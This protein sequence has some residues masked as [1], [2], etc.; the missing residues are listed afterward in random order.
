[1][2]NWFFSGGMIPLLLTVCAVCLTVYLRGQPF[3]SP[4]RMLAALLPKAEQQK[5][6]SPFR[7]LMLALAGTLGVGNI[8]GV[9]NAIRIGGA[10]AVFWMWMSSLLAMILKY[11][12]ILLAV[13]H[14][15]S[16]GSRFFGGAY[17]YIKDHFLS[18][19]MPRTAAVLSG[20]F[21]LFMILNALGMGCVIQVNAIS[22]AA[23]GIAGLPT[24]LCGALLA[25]LAMPVIVKGSRGI[26]KLTELLVPVM[27]A[28]YLI[29]SMAVLILRHELVG[30]ALAAIITDAFDAKSLGGGLLGFLTSRAVRIGTMRGLLSNEAGC[31]T[32]PT[33]HASACASSPAAQGVFG[34]VEVFVDTLLLCSATALVILVGAP[35]PDL[36]GEDAVMLTVGAFSAVLGNWAAWFLLGA[37]L[38]FGYA[39]LLC[40]AGYGLE[41]L[42]FLTRRRR[43]RYLY[44]FLTLCSILLGAVAAP[45]SVWTLT[46]FAITALTC[47]NLVM[48]ILMRK[49]VRRETVRFCEKAST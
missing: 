17:Y 32:A 18:R 15:R 20:I 13:A 23:K 28:G 12:E 46:D 27:T 26:S 16:C 3:R 21:A 41:A 8:V 29:L 40:W 37:I 7:A 10:G 5:G 33:A 1:M 47:I 6:T 25:P 48:L 45:E 2:L 22:S 36:F 34:I 35:H 44:F 11:A 42:T 14:R 49:T 30:G 43:W 9:A 19:R 38:A 24:W 31:G 4:Q 39:T